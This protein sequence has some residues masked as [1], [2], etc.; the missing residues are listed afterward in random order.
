MPR[1]LVA[2][3]AM[4]ALLTTGVVAIPPAVASSRSSPGL[5]SVRPRQ[6][7]AG[8]AMTWGDNTAGELGNDSLAQSDVPVAVHGLTGVVSAAAGGRQDLALLSNGTVLA[9]GDD[10]FGELGHGVASS[11]GDSEHPVAV[12]GLAGVTAVAAGEADSLALLSNGTVMAWGENDN[13]QLG[14]G[15]FTNSD[16]PV[17]V[18]GLSGVSAIAAGRSV[19][20]SGV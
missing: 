14:D 11:N 7:D 10:T 17:A 3:T 9:W 19:R 4:A 20:R 2:V 1:F 12:P 13:G 16:V 15:S 18:S 6:A 8:T 5:T